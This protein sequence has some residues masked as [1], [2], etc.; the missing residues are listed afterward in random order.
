MSTLSSTDYA[1]IRYFILVKGDITRW[2][3]WNEKKALV[4]KLHP[5]LIV[6][7]EQKIVADRT[8]KA[9]VESLPDD[10]EY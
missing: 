6:A 5:E 2:V 9:I 4:Q 8:I 1:M 7:L 10:I 3:Y